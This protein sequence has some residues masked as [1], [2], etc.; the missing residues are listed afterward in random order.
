MVLDSLLHY[1]I[2]HL[3]PNELI[4]YLESCRII[5]AKSPYSFHKINPMNPQPE[6]LKPDS[7]ADNLPQDRTRI[8]PFKSQGRSTRAP[9]SEVWALSPGVL[10]CLVYTYIH[11]Y[12]YR[13]MYVLLYIY[14]FIYLSHF[15]IHMYVHT[16][17]YIYICIHILT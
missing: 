10:K 16:C 2:E 1:G 9:M 12:I 8:K 13:Y 6:A 7:H 14:I 11:I 5:P 4:D 17:V 15:L 3:T